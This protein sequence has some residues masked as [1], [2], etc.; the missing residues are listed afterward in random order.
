[1][2]GYFPEPYP[3]E[4]FYSLCARFGDRMQYRSKLATTRDLFGTGVPAAIVDLPSHLGLFIE[5]LPPGHPCKDA[6]R[7]IDD[8][9]LLPFYGPFQPVER[10]ERVRQ[11]MLGTKGATIYAHVGLLSSPIQRPASLRY[12]SLCVEEDRERFGECYWH[13][14]HQIP[15]VEVCPVHRVTLEASGVRARKNRTRHEFV[16]AERAIQEAVTPTLSFSVSV[17]QHL[18][19][20]A[21]GAA[22]LLKQR[23][24]AAGPQLLYQRYKLLLIDRGL[25]SSRGTVKTRMLIQSFKAFYPSE[26]LT[27]VHCDI[28]EQARENWL[29][30]LTRTSKASQ[31]P[32]QHLLLIHFLGCTA[33]DF[34][35]LPTNPQPAGSGL[36]LSRQRLGIDRSKPTAQAAT[37]DPSF[38]PWL[39]HRAPSNSATRLGPPRVNWAERDERL[40]GEVRM[41]VQYLKQMS[42]RPVRISAD[43]I[44]RQV[45]EFR[46]LYSERRRLPLTSK[47]LA[48][49]VENHDAFAVRR[50]QWAAQLYQD[51]SICPKRWELMARAGIKTHYLSQW[52]LAREALESALQSL[53]S[54][55]AAVPKSRS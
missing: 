41:A 48:E 6:A 2:I 8:H 31:H 14:I 12:C 52:P 10:I 44:G 25:A 26:F 17:H 20:V 21:G 9:T 37:V 29:T 35:A 34:F 50:I 4:V 13:R 42:G 32:L 3:D 1:M 54:Q 36:S 45:G 7:L 51:E 47:V 27:L 28:P 11:V 22:W 55:F 23:S 38:R 39:P 43:A 24:L 5:A 49:L 16:A 30:R 46:A 53:N 40:A 19:D 18:L 15:G 33:D